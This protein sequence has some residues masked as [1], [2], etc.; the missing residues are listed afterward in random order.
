MGLEL[1][2]RLN[3]IPREPAA[4]K[5]FSCEGPPGR[6]VGPKQKAR[7]TEGQWW[8]QGDPAAPDLGGL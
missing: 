6:C 8:P 7:G 5:P 4:S 1:S 2:F 3:K